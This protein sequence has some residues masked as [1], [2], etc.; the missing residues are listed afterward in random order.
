MKKLAVVALL[1]ANISI[2]LVAHA[3]RYR[4]VNDPSGAPMCFDQKGDKALLRQCMPNAY[5]VAQDPSGAPMCF[6]QKGNKALLKN[7]Q[8]APVYMTA[9]DPSGA[10]MCFTDQGAKALLKRCTGEPVGVFIAAR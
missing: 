6:D 9:Y 4:M 7:C 8:P 10:P 3:D 1:F 2:P 5:T